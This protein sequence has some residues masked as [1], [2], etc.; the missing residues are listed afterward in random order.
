MTDPR[1]R[2]RDYCEP[3]HY[4]GKDRPVA[5]RQ[6]EGLSGTALDQLGAAR[7][8]HAQARKIRAALVED[9]LTAMQYADKVGIDYA[10]LGRILRGDIIMRVEDII[11][12]ERNLLLGSRPRIPGGNG[13]GR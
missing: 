13:T 12:A 2:P 5:W 4:F 7:W 10:R 3:P 1:F 6:G 11:N 8:Q 9:K